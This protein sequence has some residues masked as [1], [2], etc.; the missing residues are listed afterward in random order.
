M[1]IQQL[2]AVIKQRIATANYP[3][4]YSQAVFSLKNATQDL[5]NIDSIEDVKRGM[6]NSDVIAGY[7]KAIKSHDLEERVRIF[8]NECWARIGE[9]G[10]EIPDKKHGISKG[11]GNGKG[12]VQDP[13]SRSSIFEAAGI[14]RQ[15]VSVAMRLAVLPEKKKREFIE[16]GKS[17]SRLK[18]EL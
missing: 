9:L 16:S 7:A 18:V 11:I 12:Q 5:R 13:N 3:S 8:K 4:S 2:P 1:K 10:L 14:P 17:F 15:K 6:D